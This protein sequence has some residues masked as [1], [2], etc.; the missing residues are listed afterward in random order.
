MFQ[1][2]VLSS[3]FLESFQ[4]SFVNHILPQWLVTPERMEARDRSLPRWAE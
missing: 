2:L 4:I 1:L 3:E